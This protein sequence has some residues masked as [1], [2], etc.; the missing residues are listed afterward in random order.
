MMRIFEPHSV[1]VAQATPPVDQ[2]A[3][4]SQWKTFAKTLFVGLYNPSTKDLI[5]IEPL[6]GWAYGRLR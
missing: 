1:A 2:E 4:A 3:D 5:M 6:F